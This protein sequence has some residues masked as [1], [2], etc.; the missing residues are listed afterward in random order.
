VP[1]LLVTKKMSPE[2][3]ARV[4][5]SV[6]G[7]RAAPGA[8]L[9]P[10]SISLLRFGLVLVIVS[11]SSWLA[12]SIRRAHGETEAQR[13]ALLD[14]VDNEASSLGPDELDTLARISPW[15]A[16]FAGSYEGDLVADELRAPGA[17]A[18]TLAQPSVYVRGP[19]SGF[20]GP[21]DAETA[22]TS[23]PDAL[24]LC[25]IQ[26]PKERS[27]KLLRSK[28]RASYTSRDSGMRPTAHVERLFDAF[29][30]LPLLSRD[31]RQRVADAGS[32][33]EL[34]KLQRRFDQAP[35]EGAKRAA[36]ARYLLLAMDEPGDKG[37]PTE[38]DGERPHSVRVGLINLQTK[39]VLFR[40]RRHVDPRW[41]SERSR[42]ELAGGIDGCDLALQI[43]QAV[44]GEAEVARGQ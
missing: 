1:T 16:L 12:L 43:H 38:L 11:L 24:V 27:E 26:P 3:A 8:R 19:I 29:V 33:E 23:F 40:L 10:T 7:R 32:F 18:K 44:S 22:A 42:A 31:W 21:H 30:A 25:L 15:L 4:Q 9:K 20:G 2:L 14:R 28:A 35:L 37:G 34:T 13:A 39:K 6:Q 36:R 17:F 41:V 5:A